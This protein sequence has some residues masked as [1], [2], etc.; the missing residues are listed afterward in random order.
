MPDLPSYPGVPR[1]VKISLAA[2]FVA[3]LAVVILML[4]SGGRHGPQRHFPPGNASGP[5]AQSRANLSPSGGSDSL[6]PS[7]AA[8]E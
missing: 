4:L 6:T 7:A 1:W 3:I 5:A 8:H 2:V